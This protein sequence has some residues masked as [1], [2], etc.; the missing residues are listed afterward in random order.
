MAVSGGWIVGT[1]VGTLIGTLVG[2]E[3]GVEVAPPVG[4]AT[5]VGVAVPFFGVSFGKKLNGPHA[6]FPN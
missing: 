3:A 5:R 4:D 6:R 2:V 1:V